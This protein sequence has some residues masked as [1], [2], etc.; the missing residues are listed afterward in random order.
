[1]KENQLEFFEIVSEK[2]CEY[3]DGNGKEILAFTGSLHHSMM[4]VACKHD[5]KLYLELMMTTLENVLKVYGRNDFW[6]EE[7]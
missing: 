1:M 2:V 6:D 7:I 5:R 3:F 4:M